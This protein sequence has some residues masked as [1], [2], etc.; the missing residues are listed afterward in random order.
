MCYMVELNMSDIKHC[1]NF[2]LIKTVFDM[3]ENPYFKRQL[4]KSGK[5]L[6]MQTMPES[7]SS[8]FDGDVLHGKC[9]QR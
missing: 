2:P 8:C 6:L 3:G 1:L 5:S 7:F 4:D 9:L